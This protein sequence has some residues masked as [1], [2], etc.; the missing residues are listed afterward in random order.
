MCKLKPSLT[1]TE[2]FHQAVL[3]TAT[4]CRFL[5]TNIENVDT[6]LL[7]MSSYIFISGLKVHDFR[8]R[9]QTLNNIAKTVLILIWLCM[10]L[11]QKVEINVS[12]SFS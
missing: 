2:T 6:V 8:N 7:S 12:M 5:T 4:G 9:N 3:L 10:L 11:G 1:K